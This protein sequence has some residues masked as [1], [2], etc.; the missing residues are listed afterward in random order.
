MARTPD[1]FPGTREEEEVCYTD[2]T[3]DGDPTDERAVRYVSSEFRM[4]DAIGVF[5]PRS[6]ADGSGPVTLD[7]GYDGT[8]SGAGRTIT[9]DNGAIVINQSTSTNALEVN[10]TGAGVAVKLAISNASGQGLVYT[11]STPTTNPIVSI[12]RNVSASA[13]GAG[14]LYQHDA[15]TTSEL[16]GFH[17]INDFATRNSVRN[18]HSPM[19]VF[20]GHAYN[21][22]DG[23]HEIDWGAKLTTTDGISI[24]DTYGDLAFLYRDADGA[25]AFIELVTFKG[26][27]SA[28]RGRIIAKGL[29]IDGGGTVSP[30]LSVTS[31]GSYLCA[32]FTQSSTTSGAVSITSLA[33]GGDV[34]Q[35]TGLSLTTGDALQIRV[36]NTMTTGKA[37]R[38]LGGVSGA[39]NVWNVNEDG[40][41]N[42]PGLPFISV[43]YTGSANAQ[44]GLFVLFNTFSYGGTVVTDTSN[45]IVYAGTTGRF[46]VPAGGDGTYEICVVA[47]MEQTVTGAMAVWQ[48]IK[49][50]STVLWGP[51][52]GVTVI[53]SSVDPLPY[54]INIFADLVAGDY[55]RVRADSYG[56]NSLWVRVGTT[57]CMKKIA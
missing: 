12:T 2:R 35:L 44:A 22:Q 49:N 56:A 10:Q 38:V 5:N 43:K 40:I 50:S 53:H 27:M 14:I 33:A 9:V 46:T 11:E 21:D 4:K 34:L 13:T 15:I 28:D 51:T 55:I 45:G 7:T 3:A 57:F 48:V 36:D 25:G 31:Q 19:L 41:V 52:G 1:R 39:T 26:G 24:G 20:T 30:V 16:K 42:N 6:T 17:I 32:M 18:Q 8:G 47:T 29:S 54:T 23:D 37:I